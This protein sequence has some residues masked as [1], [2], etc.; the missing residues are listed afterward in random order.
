LLNSIS[1]N[2]HPNKRRE[3]Q[4]LTEEVVDEGATNAVTVDLERK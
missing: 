4:K 3:K 1:G 2:F